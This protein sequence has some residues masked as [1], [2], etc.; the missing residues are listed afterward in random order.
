MDVEEWEVNINQ[1]GDLSSNL[2]HFT[3]PVHNLIGEFDSAYILSKILSHRTLNGSTTESGFI[4]GNKSAV[5]LH[6]IPI[7]YIAKSMYRY[8]ENLDKKSINFTGVGLCFS[9]KFIYKSGGRPVIYDKP[10][11]AKQYL[12]KDEWWRIVNLDLSSDKNIIDWTHEREWRVPHN[13]RFNLSDVII[14][15]PNY[16]VYQHLLYYCKLLK[17]DIVNN[18]K[19]VFDIKTFKYISK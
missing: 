7:Q 11:I 12:D 19:G 16:E 15:V 4:H 13:L 2:I 10:N 14:I 5:C 1:R 18:T 17:L 8:S 6:D 3:K 9:K